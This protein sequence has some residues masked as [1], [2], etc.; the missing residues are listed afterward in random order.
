[1]ARPAN[2]P[3]RPRPATDRPATDRPASGRAAPDP[4]GARSAPDRAAPE[5]PAPDRRPAG[6]RDTSAR[7]PDAAR[8]A[9]YDL[10]GAVRERGAYANLAL[11]SL[12]RE[13][14]LAGRD[15]A[16]ATE[17]SYG[18]LRAQG[19]LD[20]I[21]A[22]AADRPA[23]DID[24]AVLD[25]LR[26]GAYQLLRTRVPPHAAVSATVALART[27]LGPRPVG[28]V[29]AVL[30]RV[31][32]RDEASWVDAVAP[33][34]QSDPIGHLA[35]RHAHPEWIV[36][37][38]ADALG[39]DLT[40]TARALAADDARP[41]LHLVA[42]PGRIDQAELAA[43]SAGEP[44]PWSP[45]AVR[46]PAGGDPGRLAAIRD[47]RA[48]VQDEGSQ[49]C[50]L[51]LATAPL[52]HLTQRRN[53][54]PGL[55]GQFDPAGQSDPG[56]QSDRA[57]RPDAGSQFDPGSRDSRWLDLCA[58]PG[59]KAALLGA[60]AAGR[61]AGVLAVERQPARARLVAATT[62]DLPVAVVQADGTVPA[63]PPGSFDRVLVDAPCT[64]LGALRRRPEA[65]WR[66]Q[67]T[68]VPPL[69]AL[70][71]ALLAAAIDAVRPGGVLGYVTCSPH[72]A[73]TRAVVGEVL[74]RH[75]VEAI[76]ARPLFPGVP[77]LGP[78][79]YVQL[80]PHRHGTDAMFCALL[81][82]R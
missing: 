46:L 36:A 25:A 42:R 14:R 77:D 71:R 68:D 3:A 50:A 23:T 69:T 63:W 47:G 79:P 32:E 67:P 12:L 27:A 17:L 13:R 51:A 70:Q 60:L 62:A 78:G 74:R 11:P 1:L 16:F 30:R 26:L 43:Q 28:F 37:A 58:G 29:N 57:V 6:G 5:R 56:S 53:D 19:T 21:L 15:A 80:W 49:L 65:R 81:R 64:G 73:E 39:G 31:A 75:P 44:G 41:E 48:G 10:L 8:R 45:Y 24:P 34:Y 35:L 7:P 59:G 82:R 61:G 72:L 54:P 4:A 18:T 55:A 22:R 20:A 2:R 66:R 9:A 33:P 38:F 76:D 40:E 52:D